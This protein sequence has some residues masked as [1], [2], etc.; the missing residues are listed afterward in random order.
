MVGLALREAAALLKAQ[1]ASPFRSLAYSR[2]AATI[3]NLDEDIAAIATGGME[4]LDAI[5]NIGTGIGAAILELVSTGRW[6]QLDRLRGGLEPEA[7]FRTIPGIGP[8]LAHLIHEHLNVDTLEALESAAY[9]GRLEKVPGIGARR[10]SIIRN[11]LTE[12]LSRRRAGRRYHQDQS[13]PPVD[14]LLDVDQ[15]YR[16]KAEAGKLR[17]IAPRRFNPTGASWLPILHTER[18]LWH[19][20]AL[21]S[22][23]ARAHDLG[24]T[25]DWVIIFFSS[26]HQPE[27]QCTVVTETSGRNKGKRAVR[28]R[29]NEQ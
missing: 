12:I 7:T 8:K 24:R 4:A 15:E 3:E 18:G 6:S 9:D 27:G 21:Y 25:N 2:A 20:T 14:M 29:E 19:F 22:N 26:D 13:M 28:G 10:L 11:A 17:Q 5:P 16:A 1:D 23:T